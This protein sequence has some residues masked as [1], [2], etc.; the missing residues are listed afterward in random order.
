MTNVADTPGQS[1]QISVYVHSDQLREAL[2]GEVAAG[3]LAT[4]KELSPKW[5]YDERGCELFDQ[6]TQLREYYPTRA[7]RS[8][9][10]SYASEIHALSVAN[11]LIELGSGTSDKTRLLL[12]AFQDAQ[13]L[14]RFLAFDV[15]DAT[16]RDAVAK[17][18]ADYPEAEVAGIVG[19]FTQDLSE[20]PSAG[21][22]M[23]AFLGGTIG[24]F[25][26]TQ[27][28]AFLASLAQILK[29]G[30]SLLLGTDLIKE[31]SRLLAAYD[32]SSGVTAAFNKNLLSV[33][34]AEL[35]AEFDL[36][37]FEHVACF[38]E[39]DSC[40]EMRLRSTCDQQIAIRDLDLNIDFA[41]GEDLL[42]EISTKFTVQQVE[43]ELT[44]AG[45]RT[46]H[47]WTDTAKDFALWL[48]IR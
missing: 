29:P 46:L 14:D 6:I 40:I 45:F 20:L 26:A 43:G 21:T 33:L 10:D 24:N 23:V 42:S 38:N 13:N 27:R 34:N 30:D 48:A 35:N 18:H 8:I 7:E 37:T 28:K 2:C 15:A 32:D 17:I 36:D 9:L 47:Y 19:D 11:T 1:A 16:L 22:R 25:H 31:R 12:D 44:D 41:A 3:L 5:L 39:V 4:Q